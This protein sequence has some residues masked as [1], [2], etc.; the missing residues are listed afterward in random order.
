MTT[1]P[2]DVITRHP[3]ALETALAAADADHRDRHGPE[4]AVRPWYVGEVVDHVYPNCPLLRRSLPAGEQPR[5]GAGDLYPEAGDV[6][7]WCLRVW[8]ARNTKES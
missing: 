5:E 7:G 1:H 6:C 3:T 2:A 4:N 8:R